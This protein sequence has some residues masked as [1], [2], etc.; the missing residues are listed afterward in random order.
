MA[1]EFELVVFAAEE[2]DATETAEAGEETAEAD[3]EASEEVGDAEDD[4]CTTE[5]FEETGTTT[6]VS[7]FAAWDSRKATVMTRTMEKVGRRMLLTR[8]SRC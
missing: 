5:T 3:E 8:E 1:A 6:G 2:L 7:A 4:E